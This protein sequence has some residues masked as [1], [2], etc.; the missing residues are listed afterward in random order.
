MRAP[1]APLPE[2]PKEEEEEKAEAEEVINSSF[3]RVYLY[4]L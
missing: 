3:R 4:F 2:A 1:L